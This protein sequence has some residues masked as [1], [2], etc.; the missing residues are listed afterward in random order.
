MNKEI[1][2]R[3]FSIAFVS[4]FLILMTTFVYLPSQENLSSAF[5]FLNNQKAFYMHDVTKGVLL[6]NA[7]PTKDSEGLENDPYTFEVVNNTNKNITYNIVFKNNEEK[8]K[9]KG[10]EILPS[11][12]LRFALSNINEVF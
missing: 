3:L 7:I 10:M 8:A 9:E 5:A 11:K 4:T 2:K 12:Y 1:R 6:H